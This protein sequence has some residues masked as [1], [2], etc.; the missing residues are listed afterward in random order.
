[1]DD[2]FDRFRELYQHRWGLNH[3]DDASKETP[4]FWDEKSADFAAKAHSPEA[5]A[6]A[7]EFLS[8][9]SWSPGETVL[10]VAAGP[11]T[12][13]IP[14]AKMVKHVTVTDF[15][16]G[17][18]EQ[19]LKRAVAEHVN[20]LEVVPGRWLEINSP[21]VFDTV[22]CLNSLGVVATDS[23][24]QP[25]LVSALK[26]LFDACSRRLIMLIP[27]ADSPLEPQMRKILGLE[28]ISVE[29]RRIAILYY[30]MVDC[31]M[32]P[33]LEIICRPFRWTFA[34]PEEAGETLMRKAGVKDR[35][36]NTAKFADYLSTRLI[37][38]PDGRFN[39]VYNVSQALFSWVRQ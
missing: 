6:E 18:L 21:G 24:H 32:L 7:V 16:T 20:N 26:K 2:N 35:A 30:A 19:L 34:S 28:E 10:D 36:K 27:H 25:Q 12:F 33:N 23:H 38:D 9:F 3:G 15:S 17:M 4:S 39:L 5:R 14:L 11:G 31:G 37:R 29:R 8:R 13:A 22:L 1:M